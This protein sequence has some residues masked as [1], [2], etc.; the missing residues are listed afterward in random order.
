MN[1]E[2]SLNSGQ[3]TAELLD[4]LI[5]PRFANGRAS[6]SVEFLCRQKTDASVQ[7]D[8]LRL[9][10]LSWF[11]ANL[12][13]SFTKQLALATR[14]ENCQ[15]EL[16]DAGLRLIGLSGRDRVLPADAR[17]IRVEPLTTAPRQFA[18]FVLKGTQADIRTYARK[19]YN[20][21]W[22]AFCRG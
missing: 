20:R 4:T 5:L 22:E 9:P 7:Q 6:L 18:P 14:L 19:L 13:Q 8:R 15:V 21:L 2:L 17:A 3:I 1:V 11:D 16:P 12:L 10:A